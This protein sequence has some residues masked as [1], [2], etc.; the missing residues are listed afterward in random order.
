[1]SQRALEAAMR[2][3][4]SL[5]VY[6]RLVTSLASRRPTVARGRAFA[7]IKVVEHD[8]CSSGLFGLQDQVPDQFGR[9]AATP[10]TRETG[11]LCSGTL[12]AKQPSR[13]RGLRITAPRGR[14]APRPGIRFAH[15]CAHEMC[16]SRWIT[17]SETQ[18]TSRATVTDQQKKKNTIA[19]NTPINKYQ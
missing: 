12:A 18:W 17:S 10:W 7:A 16:G 1:M 6:S 3:T 8:P 13:G 15:V 2:S 11:V 19:L 4:L 5:C 9:A 14:P